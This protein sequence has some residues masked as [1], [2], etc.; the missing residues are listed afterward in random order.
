MLNTYKTLEFDTILNEV[1]CFALSENA[2]NKILQLK[3]F[4][5]ERECKNRMN[6]TT[7]A[8]LIIESI[9]NPPLAVMTGLNEIFTLAEK[10]SMLTPAQLSC[11]AVFVHT[12][13]RMAAFLKKAEQLDISLAYYG[14]SFL[15][16]TELQSEIETAIRN[17]KVESTASKVLQ[18]IRRKIENM[19]YSI[20]AKLE[21]A[22]RNKKAYLSDSNIVVRNGR[23]A[24]PVKK[25]Y[26][27][28]ISGAVIDTSNTGG[29]IFIEPSSV[30]KA[31]AELGLLQIEEENEVRRI[32]YALTALVDENLQALNKNMGYMDTLDFAFAKAKYSCEIRASEVPI[33]TDRVIKIVKGRHPLLNRDECV[34]LTLSL[35][36]DYTG[37]VITGPNTGGKTVALKTVGLLSLMAQCGLHVP[38]EEGSTFSMHA[39]ILCDIGDGQS[40]KESLSTFSA[41]ITNIVSILKEVSHESLILLDELG[42]GTDP[43]EGMGI[44][45]AILDELRK[46]KCL[47]LATTHYPE[48]KEYAK[49][50]ASL[51]NARMKFDKE[52]LKPLYKLE[53]GEA[54]ESCA[55]SIA[56][57][58][59]LPSNIL[60]R[61][62]KEAY[63]EEKSS[64]APDRFSVTSADE[65][66]EVV[67]KKASKIIKE[68]PFKVNEL[69][70]LYSIGDSVNVLSDGSIGIV[71]K[72]PNEK[73]ELVIQVKGKKYMINHTRVK[74][75]TKAEELYPPDYDF[76]IIF[77]TVEN[78]K[79]RHKM[80]KG[81]NPNLIINYDEFF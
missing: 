15:N 63:Y 20:K 24:L 31:Q 75:K 73:G 29:T 50:T 21:E 49:N 37:I 46:T 59:G 16:L 18:D 19:N 27:N 17:D 70:S 7:E 77:D 43:A 13:N 34:P 71:Y 8:K 10:G 47:F 45:V 78:R 9:G 72:P 60:A 3:P 55:L 12:C 65:N 36:E 44:A 6:D 57:R 66:E 11:V 62:K 69:N 68:K 5:N 22:L 4:L 64:I 80:K 25:E 1:S 74:L 79:A 26:K 52:N 39:N 40:I 76:D 41:H 32:L 67:E 48:I 53:V 51:T 81:H 2:K 30:A 28:Q 23:Y 58:L 61:A 33:N 38:A 14:M 54:G 42:S 35:G 56:E